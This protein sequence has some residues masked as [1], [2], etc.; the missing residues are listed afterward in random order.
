MKRVLGRSSHLDLWSR[1]GVSGGAELDREAVGVGA[2]PEG[3]LAC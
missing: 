2:E 1:F 3:G